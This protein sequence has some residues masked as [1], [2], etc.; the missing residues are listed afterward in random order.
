MSQTWMNFLEKSFFLKDE[1]KKYLLQMNNHDAYHLV[2]K[3]IKPYRLYV[4]GQKKNKSLDS[5]VWILFLCFDI[6]V[7]SHF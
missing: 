7:L 5:L 6:H 3:G 4:D 2:T 1:S